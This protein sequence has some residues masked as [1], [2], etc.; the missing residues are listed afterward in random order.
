MGGQAEYEFI[1]VAPIE[2]LPVGERLFLELD[3]QTVVVF[4]IGGRLCAIADLCTHDNGPLGEG[5]LD[6]DQIICPR[7][8]A[9]FD[10]CSGKALT[11]PAVTPTKAYPVRVEDGMIS[12][13]IEK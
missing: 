4:N 5:E 6:G 10:A 2:D 1:E 8:G 3:D 9:R 7:H 13:G 12:I 11:L